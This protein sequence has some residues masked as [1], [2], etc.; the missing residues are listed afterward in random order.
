M[1][2]QILGFILCLSLAFLLN[3]FIVK[4]SNFIEK[5]ANE[6]NPI[7]KIHQNYTPPLG[8]IVIVICFYLYLSLFHK[9]S[10]YLNWYVFVPLML[11]TISGLFEDLYSNVSPKVRLLLIF[12]SSM[13]FCIGNNKFPSLELPL[14][15]NLIND[16]FLIK[17]L[18]YTTALSALTNGTNMIDGMNGLAGLTIISILLA[19]L[20]LS[21]LHT[22]IN[23]EINSILLMIG[24]ITVF[25][26]FNFPWGKIFLGDAGS[27]SLG[28]LIGM[29]VISIFESKEL[30]TWIAVI[31][32]FYPTIEVIFSTFRKLIQ[33]KNP[34]SPDL[35]H[36]HIKLY[37]SLKG[38][39]ERSREFNSFTTLCLMPFWISPLLLVMWSN[40]YSHL[41]FYL[42]MFM[43]ILYLVYYLFIPK[44]K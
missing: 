44:K 33:K 12:V 2:F 30:N 36:L 5:I 9:S 27:Y 22:N 19:I 11:I 15:G 1:V 28:M 26:I 29:S 34:M 3:F 7:Q 24:L 43:V 16:Y 13:I 32:L 20:G 14:I 39:V 31:L 35:N 40:Y 41:S 18:F 37:Y 17:L 6:Y 8:G 38:P 25:L 42:I 4:K 10:F 21:H 23:I